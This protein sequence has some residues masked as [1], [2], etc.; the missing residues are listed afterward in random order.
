[1]SQAAGLARLSRE[2]RITWLASLMGAHATGGVV[3]TSEQTS[4]L[5]AISKLSPPPNREG[6]GCL[7]ACGGRYR[8][9]RGLIHVKC[10]GKENSNFKSIEYAQIF[11]YIGSKK[12][13]S[14]K[15]REHDIF[16]VL[17]LKSGL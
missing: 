9:Q 16:N 5:G 6:F 7:I 15:E 2:T 13:P 11:R 1:M 17:H 12:I 4:S 8:Y 10:R 3:L 14:K